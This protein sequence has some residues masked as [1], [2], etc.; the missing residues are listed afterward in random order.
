MLPSRRGRHIEATLVRR[1]A[2]VLLVQSQPSQR[3]GITHVPANSFVVCRRPDPAAFSALSR[4]RP[5][6]VGRM[7]SW[8]SQLLTVRF[9]GNHMCLDN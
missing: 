1:S 6:H 7:F 2:I 8:S 5:S 3:T 4:T 9:K